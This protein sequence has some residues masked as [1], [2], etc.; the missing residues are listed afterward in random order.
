MRAV[1]LTV[2]LAGSATAQGAGADVPDALKPWKAWVLH[3]QEAW[4]CPEVAG[5]HRND[6]CA[7]PGELKLDVREGGIQFTQTWEMRR[8]SA[9]PLPGS[10]EYWPQQVTVDGRPHP[11][12]ARGGDG[13]AETD[14][15]PVVWLASGK[16]AVSGWIPWLE[17]PQELPVPQNVALVALFVDGRAV[18][19]LTR[20]DASVMLG[21]IGEAPERAREEDSLDVQVY[22]K[23]SDGIPARLTTRI[24]FKVS[25]KARELSVPEIL[26]AH[27]VPVGIASPWAARLDQD[28]RL[29]VQ[30][31][32]GQATVEIAA[33]LDEPLQEVTPRLPPQREQEVWSY[34][35]APALRTT[36]ILPG[37]GDRAL[38]VDPRQA[39]VPDDWQGLP[40]LAVSEG[41]RLQV[42]ERSRGQSEHEKQRLTLQRE[43]WLD[44][45]GKGFF[46]RDRIE[47]SMR[48]GWRFDV[49]QPYK[50][51]RADSLAARTSGGQGLEAALLVTQGA[52]ESLTGV[53]WR[54]PQVTLNAGVRL[55][56][57]ASARVPV[58]GWRQAFDSVDATLH[59]P[60][61]YRLLAAPGV[62][63]VSGNVWVEHWTMLEVFFAAFFTLLAW[64]LFGVRGGVAA[65]A[66]LMLAMPEPLAPVQSFAVAVVLA[67]LHR[68]LPEGRLRRLFRVGQCLALA[69]LVMAAVIFIPVQIR[70]TLYPQLENHASSGMALGLPG[71]EQMMEVAADDMEEDMKI[72]ADMAQSV[73]PE[74]APAPSIERKNERLVSRS[75]P[76]MRQRYAQSSVTQTGGGEPAW[77]LGQRYRLHWSGPVAE[78]Q[79]VRLLVSSPWLTRLL[80]LTTIAL[81]GLLIWNLIRIV[82]PDVKLPPWLSFRALA[83]PSGPPPAGAVA[84]TPVATVSSLACTGFAVLLIAALGFPAPAAAGPADGFPPQA[85]LDTLK[86]RLLMPPECAPACVDV[87]EA[88]IEAEPH[89]LRVNLVAHA[90]APV[91]LPLP[92]PGEHLGLR[93]VRVNGVTYA[94][95]RFASNAY[96]ALPEGIHRVQIEYAPGS[97][98][99]SLSFPLPPA[100]V[101]FAG[102]GWQVEGIDES[103]L[104]SETLNFSRTGATGALAGKDGA[105]GA[106]LPPDRASQQFPVFVQVR[107]NIDLD[108]D[109]SV[110]TEVHRIAPVEGG[111]SLPVPLLAGEHVTTPTVKVQDGRALAVFAA[112]TATASW[113][114][115][116]DKAPTLELVAPP[117]SE[118]AETWRVTVSPSWHLEW[119]GVP[120]TLAG[121]GRQAVFEYHPLPGEKLTLTV[122]Q[123]GEVEGSVMAIDRVRLSDSVGEHASDYQL[124]FT[125][126][127]SRGG[128]HRIALPP[129]LEVLDVQRDGVRLNLQA[130]DNFLSL[131]VSPGTQTYAI[132]LRRQADVGLIA[133]TPAID[134]GLPVAN[135]D[136]RATLG[137]QRWVL[138]ASG[139]AIG[140][141]VLYWGELLAALA[142]AF[143]L[144]RSGL[145]SLGYREWLLLV[146][147]FS[148]FSWLTLLLIVF[149]LIVIDWR[150]RVV[151]CADWSAL[152]FNAMQAGIVLLTVVMLEQLI[153]AVSEGLLSVPGMGIAGYGSSAGR[154]LWFADQSGPLLPVAKVLSLPIWV[155][156]LLMLA[157]ALWLAYILI[158]WLG[159]GLAAWLRDGYWKKYSNGIR[160]NKNNTP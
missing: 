140:P 78:K 108:L 158:R 134:L 22:R 150:V 23:L 98:T 144:A 45:S 77:E 36:A 149:W 124:G 80:R 83:A 151:A 160:E 27:F 136:L 86:T 71:S 54:Q 1:A 126:R 152:K 33:R 155:Y 24:R 85:L 105:D 133:A 16:H 91:S 111:F 118:R 131:P 58:T 42:E 88:R 25:G 26:P 21:G 132:S 41:A 29:L 75:A 137:G 31:L 128:E 76:A 14:A 17:R 48:Q 8:E 123:P 7:W 69:G 37:D 28:G 46:A 138:A 157:W 93:G 64:R 127:A 73:M 109:W 100:R 107:R 52:D 99:A 114:A 104:L 72:D 141:A 103:R 53:E 19:P 11:V 63:R 135:I 113:A 44:F 39:G 153:V 112:N 139:P 106:S 34:E 13:A 65:A 32:P 125:L 18:T 129:D 30:A 121:D 110:S 12:L 43:M 49:A 2:A 47:G 20:G 79:S 70:Y 145:T 55:A 82:F 119:N 87:A 67:L 61:G 96:V 6:F 156:R 50:L 90:G 84:S 143:L 120:V 117:L 38:A 10:R 94:V 92:Q 89:L 68:V 122:T 97:D 95:L 81:L 15:T 74:P 4:L 60:Y 147:G 5:E 130:R 3:G 146:L 9:A 40:A 159:R 66:Y 154:L 101:E 115:R 142:V 35:A 56:A 116:L 59:L 57:S 51:E 148:T 62:D 102:S